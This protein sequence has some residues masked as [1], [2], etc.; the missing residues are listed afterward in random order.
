MRNPFRA[1]FNKKIRLGSFIITCLVLV[2]A[3]VALTYIWAVGGFGS[4]KYFED[5]K[6]YIEIEKVLDENYIGD[7]DEDSLYEAAASGMVRALDDRWSYYMNEDDYQAYLLSQS[8][9]YAGIGI[10][11][12]TNADGDFEISSIFEGSPAEE[13]GLQKGMLLLAIDGEKVKGK[14]VTE[15]QTL[16]RSKLNS[17][18]ELTVKDLDGDEASFDVDCKP[19][20]RSPVSSQMLDGNI[21]YIK[22]ANFEAGSA[23]EIITSLNYLMG[24]GAKGIIF[25]VRDNPG[26]LVSELCNALDAILPKGDLFVSVDKKGR[27]KVT[28]SDKMSVKCDM[29]VLVNGNSYS[30]AEFFAAALQEYNWASIMGQQTSGKARSQVTIELSDGSAIHLSTNKYLTPGRVD[31]AA[32]GGVTPDVVVENVDNKTDSQLQAALDS[33]LESGED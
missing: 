11:I 3:A 15:V 13:A 4:A 12:L 22:I 28:K 30:A 10:G 14:S 1:F 5:A 20:Y 7:L 23:D 2:S 6:K 9:E 27:E 26:G 19:V 16:I 25:D 33:F 18:L 24:E 31:L 29:V 8:N 17:S 32:A 21:G